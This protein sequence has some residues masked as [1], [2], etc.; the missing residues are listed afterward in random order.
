MFLLALTMSVLKVLYLKE[1]RSRE[2][3]RLTTNYMETVK[4]QCLC[5]GRSSYCKRRAITKDRNRI[6]KDLRSSKQ[7]KE[8]LRG[9]ASLRKKLIAVGVSWSRRITDTLNWYTVSNEK[10]FSA[11]KKAGLPAGS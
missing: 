6:I 11:L 10:T 9:T 8:V 1:R 3:S 4:T 7:V 5:S 2:V